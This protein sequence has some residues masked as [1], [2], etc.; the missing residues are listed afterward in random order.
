MLT[1]P[2][3]S[4]IA[5]PSYHHRS[6]AMK[7]IF[8][9]VS[10][11]S[12]VSVALSWRVLPTNR[13][14]SSR[15]SSAA[16]NAVMPQKH[17]RAFYRST[18]LFATVH[19]VTIIH[20]GKETIIEADEQTSILDAALDAGIDLPHD[21]KMGVCLTCPSKI[22]SGKVDQSGST[23]EDGVQEDGYALTCATY[24]R[25]DCTVKSIDEDELVSAQ[26]AREQ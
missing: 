6:S 11:L 5:V 24:A 1:V 12:F 20:D 4:S 7:P 3:Q 16:A 2:L 18:A 17:S 15:H 10:L 22:V 25:S 14:G 8:L 21:C 13:L 19:K 23:L 9:L 26:F